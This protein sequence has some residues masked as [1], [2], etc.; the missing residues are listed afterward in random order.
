MGDVRSRAIISCGAIRIDDINY[1]ALPSNADILRAGSFQDEPDYLLGD[2]IQYFLLESA[3]DTDYLK[4]IA[5]TLFAGGYNVNTFLYL[6]EFTEPQQLKL[7]RYTIFQSRHAIAADLAKYPEISRHLIGQRRLSSPMILLAWALSRGYYEI[8]M[9]MPDFN[10]RAPKR[11]NLVEQP[12]RPSVNVPREQDAVAYDVHFAEALSK[13]FPDTAIYDATKYGATE[14]LWKKP[15]ELPSSMR[16]SPVAKRTVSSPLK[17][18]DARGMKNGAARTNAPGEAFILRTNTKTGS[19]ERCAYVTYCDSEGYFYGCRALANSLAKQGNKAPL[20]I[21]TPSDFVTTGRPF[22]HN[23]VKI[24]SVPK[25]KSPHKP[26]KHQA[27]FIY[28]YSKLNIFGLDFL[29]KAV[30]LDSDAIVLKNIDSLF[31]IDE[32]AAAPDDG[33]WFSD[34]EFNSGVFVCQP[35]TALFAEMMKAAEVLD[36]R[37][38]GD[39]GFLN[40]FFPK[41]AS[42]PRHFNTLKRVADRMPAF[43]DTDKISVLHYVGEKPWQLHADSTWGS[44]DRLWFEMLSAE[45]RLDFINWLKADIVAQMRT[46]R[47]KAPRPEPKR[48][49]TPRPEAPPTETPRKEAAREDPPREDRAREEATYGETGIALDI[50]DNLSADQYFELGR[51]HLL[52]GENAGAIHMAQRGLQLVPDSISNMAIAYKAHLR[53]GAYL[54]AALLRVKIAQLRGTQKLPIQ[55]DGQDESSQ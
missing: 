18:G 47:M 28:T 42:L 26:N 54:K 15:P 46:A 39:Q 3:S 8:F 12:Q 41:A 40:E 11:S 38:A 17:N 7:A 44:L 27:R 33:L 49:N 1:S 34:G 45:E 55:R 36:S 19:E 23:N 35:S 9:L 5:Q 31:D 53:S 20:I 21:M 13:A 32:F 48:A 25:I 24:I 50:F 29:D 52:H 4:K 2:R 37:D 30:F 51:R 6:E 43:F 10:P 14:R 16:L 22:A